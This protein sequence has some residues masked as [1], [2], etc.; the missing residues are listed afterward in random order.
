MLSLERTELKKKE[1]DLYLG[2]SK[3]LRRNSKSLRRQNPNL[4]GDK[5]VG[6]FPKVLCS[7]SL[8]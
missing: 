1:R 6:N 3:S 2:H 8:Q 4:V 5:T 7:K